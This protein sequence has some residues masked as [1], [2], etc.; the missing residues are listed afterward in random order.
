MSD[1]PTRRYLSE[2]QAADYLGFSPHTLRQ[3]RWSGK[4]AGIEPPQHIKLGRNVRYELS[5]LDS[6]MATATEEARS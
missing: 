6:W 1:I 4:L 2:R 5:T 3:S